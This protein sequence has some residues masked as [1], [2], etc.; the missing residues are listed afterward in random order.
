MTHAGLSVVIQRRRA[1]GENPGA[2]QRATQ[3]REER[4]AARRLPAQ[5]RSKGLG[6]RGQNHQVFL[7]PEM[8]A[9]RLGQ[10]LAGG[11]MDESISAIRSRSLIPTDAQRV[12]PF[13]RREN[14]INLGQAA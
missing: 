13:R 5:G 1:D 7:A 8:P 9:G 6:F 11:E 2:I 10:L 4:A 3:V 12:S 14:F